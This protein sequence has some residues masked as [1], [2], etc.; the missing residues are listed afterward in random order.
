MKQHIQ[1]SYRKS[2]IHKDKIDSLFEK[3]KDI[4]DM[5]LESEWAKYLCVLV[6]GYLEVSIRTIYI[7]YTQNKTHKNVANFV[8]SKLGGFQNP[9]MEMILQHAGAFNLDWRK[10][11]ENI[12]DE[13]KT[14]VDSIVNN[15]NKIAHG[16]NVDLSYVR[17]KEYYQNAIKMVQIMKDQCNCG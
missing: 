9:K 1:H 16:D 2:E 11:L 8:S 10:E 6:S 12:D 3:V 7:E 14:S 17:I 5:E 4:Q 13:I 15:R